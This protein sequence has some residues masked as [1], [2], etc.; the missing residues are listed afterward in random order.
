LNYFTHLLGHEG[1]NSLLS[2]LKKEDLAISLSASQTYMMW[3]W[4]EVHVSINLTKKGL[5]EYERV[6]KAVFKF[7]QIMRDAKP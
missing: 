5:K 6:I 3:A 7:N 4:S 1:P 2:Y